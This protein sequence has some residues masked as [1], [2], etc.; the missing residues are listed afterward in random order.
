MNLMKVVC[1]FV[2]VY[3]YTH[4]KGVARMETLCNALRYPL[5]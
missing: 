2:V 1:L 5:F 3:C 4:T